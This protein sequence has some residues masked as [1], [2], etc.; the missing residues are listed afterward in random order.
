MGPGVWDI[1]IFLIDGFV[2]ILIGLQLPIDPRAICADMRAG[3]ADRPRPGGQPDRDRRP[4]R[5]GLPGDLPAALVQ[6]QD[7]GAR[8]VPAAAGRLR[9]VAG[10]AC[11]AP[12]R[13]RR[14][15]RCR[16]TPLPGARP[17]HLPDLL[18]HPR[19]AGRPGPDAALAGPA[20]RARGRSRHGRRGD[21]LPA[22]RPSTP[23]STGSTTSPTSTPTTSSSSTSSRRATATRRATSGRTPRARATSPSRSYWSTS[24]SGRRSSRPS[25]RRSSGC[26]TTGSSATRCCAVERDLDLEVLRSG[27]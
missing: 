17:A 20:A 4:D 18:R 15:W 5:V 26:A 6:R 23:P 8:P 19:H 10:P 21:A 12:C 27:A 11:A 13:S 7:P 9:R 3:R 22:R 2:F 25:A 14:P 16:W 24:R 1:V